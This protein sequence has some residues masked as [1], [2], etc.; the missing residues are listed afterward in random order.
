MIPKS[1][2]PRSLFGVLLALLF[3][4]SSN[5]CVV[6]ELF[7]SLGTGLF[8]LEAPSHLPNHPG[9]HSQHKHHSDSE[10][11]SHGQPH[12]ILIFNTAKDAVDFDSFPGVWLPLTLLSIFV[13]HS[14][15]D[16]KSKK[17]F[18]SHGA[19]DPPDCT[20]RSINCLTAAPQAPPYLPLSI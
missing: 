15:I 6:E 11:H 18:L 17:V 12:P 13:L 10:S 5:H 20:I 19:N 1:M 8:S 9:S 4:G 7:V 16:W 3:L 14:K 2:G